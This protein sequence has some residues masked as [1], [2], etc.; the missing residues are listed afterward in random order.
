MADE[1]SQ[2]RFHVLIYYG[3]K[4]ISSLLLAGMTNALYALAS[5]SW[6]VGL[7]HSFSATKRLNEELE[8]RWSRLL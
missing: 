3:L 2:A 1:S 4:V 5:L 8:K 6:M 7:A